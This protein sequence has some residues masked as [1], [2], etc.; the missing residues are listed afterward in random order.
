[1]TFTRAKPAGWTDNVDTITATQMNQIDTNQSNA[2]DGA[3]GGAYTPAAE[4]E[5]DGA[6]IRSDNV[7]IDGTLEIETGGTLETQSGST[8]TVAT[9]TTADI[10]LDANSQVQTDFGASIQH[11]A[12]VRH[13]YSTHRVDF[14]ETTWPGDYGYFAQAGTG[15]SGAIQSS[16]PPRLLL[17]SGNVATNNYIVLGASITFD[18]N[19]GYAYEFVARIINN[20]TTMIFEVSMQ[21][22]SSELVAS[23][24]QHGVGV[25]FD[26]VGAGDTN[27]MLVGMSGAALTRVDSGVAVVASTWVRFRVEVATDGSAELFINGTSQATLTAGTVGGNPSRPVWFVE[28]NAAAFREFEMEMWQAWQPASA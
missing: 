11:G 26:T 17:S 19:N 3:A 6:G 22:G 18:R 25:Q 14:Y 1:M 28:T 12:Y 8:L 15:G 16:F 9:G 5:I 21:D 23:S 13:Q 24:G 2:L 20:L 10:T 4:V 27:W 7:E